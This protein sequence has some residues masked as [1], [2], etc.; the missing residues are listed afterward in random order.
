M[1]DPIETPRRP[2]FTGHIGMRRAGFAQDYAQFE[3]TLGPEHLNP[4]GIPHGGV[5]A[6]I[7]DTA[8]GS[9]GSWMGDPDRFLPSITLNLN[10]SYLS[11]PKGGTRLT[12]EGRRV[13]GGRNI[14]FAEGEVRDETGQILASATGT[15]KLV[16]PRA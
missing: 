4:L 1:N 13:G 11:Q 14:F 3:L 9:S 8:L 15:F 7:L 16:K 5:Y 6:T 12:C 10:V 2:G